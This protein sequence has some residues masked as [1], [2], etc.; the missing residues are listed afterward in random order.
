MK[1]RR[2][3]VRKISETVG[4]LLN[5]VHNILH[6]HFDMRSWRQDGVA[7]VNIHWIKNMSE[8]TLWSTIWSCFKVIQIMFYVISQKER[9]T[10]GNKNGFIG[11]KVYDWF[12]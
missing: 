11:R 10:K 6:K 4:I 8:W 1:D 9:N 2:L 12:V 3:K 5:G 7:F